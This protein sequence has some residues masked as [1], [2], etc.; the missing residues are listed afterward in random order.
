MLSIGLSPEIIR[1]IIMIKI[2]SQLLFMLPLAFG[3]G[4]AMAFQTAINTQLKDYLHSP[5]QAALISFLVG[6][7]ILAGLVMFQ[8]VEKLSLAQLAHIPW[9][10]WLGGFLGVYAVSVS[11]YTA[12][13]LGL[14]IFSGIVIFA[15]LLISMLIDHFGWF[16][17]EKIPMN[18]QR[19]LGSVV[20]FM[21]V[22]LTLQH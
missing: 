4:V 18:W 13:K 2:S 5:L 12:P 11:I 19:L 21:G 3:I 9:Y 1:S 20:I 22:V 16:G 17:A 6:T 7:V 10:L 8:S 15:Q 14:L